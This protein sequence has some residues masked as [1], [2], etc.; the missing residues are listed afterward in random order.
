[1][2]DAFVEHWVVH[3][4]YLSIFLLMAADAACIPIPSEATLT[5]GGWYAAAGKL[6][7]VEV[8]VA[9]LIG[10]WAGSI[11]AYYVGLLAG[12]PVLERYGRFVGIR[13][14]DLDRAE[15]WW[16]RHGEAATFLSRMLPVVRTYIS[17]VAGIGGM[18]VGRFTLYTIAGSI[19]WTVG[20]VAA[21]Y[22]VKDRW[23]E[24]AS[25]FGIPTIVVGALIVAA[26][27]AYVLNRRR[28]ARA[29]EATTSPDA[30]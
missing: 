22:V 11:A 20:L 30:P 10:T 14:R 13:A 5:V 21:G 9:A 3:Y 2:V 1:M 27:C 26:G 6:G 17:V 7:V 29:Q 24:I 8:V 16:D 25:S 4:G 18:P 19:P 28:R 23:Q 15:A 12:R